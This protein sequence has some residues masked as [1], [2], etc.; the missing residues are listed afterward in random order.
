MKPANESSLSPMNLKPMRAKTL[1]EATPFR[2]AGALV[3]LFTRVGQRQPPSPNKTQHLRLISITM[4]NYVEKARWGLDLLVEHANKS[5][6]YYTEDCHPPGLSAFQTVAA[7]ND[8]SS[9]APMI[10]F[11]DGRAVWGSDNILQEL[12]SNADTV[13]L[14]PLEIKEDII[15]LEQDLG[16][17]LGASARCYGYYSLLERPKSKQYYGSLAKFAT[18][19]AP[20]VER[21]VFEKMLARE[22]TKPSKNA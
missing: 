3:K 6:V 10:V 16:V 7:S 9:Q 21:I 2:V 13:N 17:R 14:Y 11:P 5:P 4:S 20:K 12:C 19:F 18:L 22:W 15:K 8:Q 1:R